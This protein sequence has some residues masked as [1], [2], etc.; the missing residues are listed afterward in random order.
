MLV[1]TSRAEKYR[2]D[3][4]AGDHTVSADA[5]TDKGGMGNA[6]RPHQIL[7]AAYAS[8]LNMTVRMVCDRL[9]VSYEGVRVVVDLQ[10]LE[11]S[12]RFTYSINFEGELSAEDRIRIIQGA[13][14]CPVRR[15]LEKPFE[16]AEVAG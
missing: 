5:T 2:C 4:T 6:M 13:E 15:T 11:K 1:C 7:E 14:S 10:R 3:A 8:C 9:G 16:F 12:N